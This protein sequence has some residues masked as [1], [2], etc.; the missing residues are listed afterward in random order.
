MAGPN[1]VS[2]VMVQVVVSKAIE[3]LKD[4]KFEN[5]VATLSALNVGGGSGSGSLIEGDHDETVGGG[6][7]TGNSH[8]AQHNNLSFVHFVGSEYAASA[9]MAASAIAVDRYNAAGLVNRANCL[10]VFGDAESAKEMYLEAI[11]VEADCVEAIYNLGVTAKKMGH[12]KDA[13]AAFLKLHKMD[14]AGHRVDPQVLFQIGHCQQALGRQHDALRTLK[15]LH[16]TLPTDGHLLVQIANLLK[17]ESPR[18]DHH[19][20]GRQQLDADSLVFHQFLESHSVYKANVAVL[21]W[22]GVYFINHSLYENAIAVF[23]DAARIQPELAKWRLM[24]ASC[25][26]RMNCFDAAI[27]IYQHLLATTAAAGNEADCELQ[28][29]CYQYLA[30]ITAQ[31]DHPQAEHYRLLLQRQQQLRQ[32]TASKQAD[33]QFAERDGNVGSGRGTVDVASSA[34]H[35]QQDQ[36]QE[37]E[38]PDADDWADCHLDDELLPS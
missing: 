5:A 38:D 1:M 9:K 33:A 2:Q 18:D 23:H 17:S 32:S 19:H 31:I 28:F 34:D 12:F 10:L 7:S 29:K 8:R 37:D 30:A 4:E 13:L 36:D 21:S 15:Q 27:R 20:D 3:L 24:I 26:R 22:L 6:V 35:R 14:A 11:G 16:L 25:H